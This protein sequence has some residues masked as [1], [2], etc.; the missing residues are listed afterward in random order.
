MATLTN[1]NSNCFLNSVLQ[2][3][4]VS[5]DIMACFNCPEMV[6]FFNLYRNGGLI[7]V[8]EIM[9]YY[10]KLNCQIVYGRH[11]DAVDTLVY[12]LDQCFDK[13]QFFIRI[14]QRVFNKKFSDVQEYEITREM[15]ES[16][17]FEI[18]ISSKT[19]EETI[20]SVPIKENIQDSIS[21]YFKE[22]DEDIYE[23]E[24]E[25][26]EVVDILD[27]DTESMVQQVVKRKIKILRSSPKIDYSPSNSP[28]YLFLSLK[29]FDYDYNKDNSFVN[30]SK[31]IMYNS[32]HYNVIGYII[33]IGDTNAG[34]YVTVKMISGIWYFYDD[35]VRK[36]ISDLEGIKLQ[37]SAY[38]YI[39]VNDENFSK[40]STKEDGTTINASLEE[41]IEKYIEGN[42]QREII[43][44]QISKINRQTI[45][46]FSMT[47][48]F[49]KYVDSSQSINL[50]GESNITTLLNKS[51]YESP[52]DFKKTIEEQLSALSK[53]TEISGQT[54][55][56]PVD[57][58]E[59]EWRQHGRH[60]IKHSTPDKFEMSITDVNGSMID[61]TNKDEIDSPLKD[62]GEERKVQFDSDK[63]EMWVEMERD[64]LKELLGNYEY[65]RVMEEDDSY[66][67]H[68]MDFP[69]TSI[70]SSDTSKDLFEE[71]EI[72]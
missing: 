57:K 50:F 10:Q 56:S 4:T 55:I 20:L 41:E 18:E 15:I 35:S 39:F 28:N 22:V 13:S 68:N 51:P 6:D 31:G 26:E 32:L 30:I 69:R 27:T 17:I 62:C 72:L 16:G 23:I 46:S 7:N 44:E 45:D 66:V 43:R 19:T 65:N 54:S 14:D 60:R 3:L 63:R 42:K 52:F 5:E 12:I 64:K 34:H 71:D 25:V 8:I 36:A 58:S 38:I 49:N 29:R 40:F 70:F 48:N 37:L 61:I 67:S 53:N 2:L 9:K 21:E 11:H 59:D 47:Q 33:H 1:K 24:R